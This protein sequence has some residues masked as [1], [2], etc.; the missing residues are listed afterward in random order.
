MKQAIYAGPITRI[1]TSGVLPLEVLLKENYLRV[2]DLRIELKDIVGDFGLVSFCRK[3]YFSSLRRSIRESADLEY[4]PLYIVMGGES[5]SANLVAMVQRSNLTPE[6]WQDNE[7]ELYTNGVI[8]ISANESI[9]TA[10]RAYFLAKG[11]EEIP[12]SK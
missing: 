11:G 1:G 4:C 8:T 12:G 5:A 6:P 2:G 10:L 9:D 3:V 7:N